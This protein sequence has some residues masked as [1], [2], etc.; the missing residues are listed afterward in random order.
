MLSVHEL[1]LYTVAAALGVAVGSVLA[2]GAPRLAARLARSMWVAGA[3]QGDVYAATLAALS[4]VFHA[5]LALTILM[6]APLLYS[7]LAMRAGDSSVVAF[8]LPALS[9]VRLA[10]L[11][12]A[13]SAASLLAL[14]LYGIVAGRAS[15]RLCPVVLEVL[16][17]ALYI[18]RSYAAIHL[19]LAI[20]ALAA[21]VVGGLH[22]VRTGKLFARAM[23]REAR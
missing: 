17:I 4:L 3:L 9:L 12:A 7:L 6:H 13:L 1:G 10:G 23:L 16:V 8:Y 19:A 5:S 14:R 18:S 15:M 2:P 20:A 22:A 11:A 21:S